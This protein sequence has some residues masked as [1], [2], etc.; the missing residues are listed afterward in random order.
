MTI[1]ARKRP[2]QVELVQWTGENL[3][4]VFDFVGE[5]PEW[6]VPYA[7]LLGF[8]FDACSWEH[9]QKHPC[10]LWVTKGKAWVALPVGD[11]IAKE[12]DEG[13]YPVAQDVFDKTYELMV[14]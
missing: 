1:Y 13:F 9:G 8:A 11:Y 7:G 14:S 4:E 3:E 6:D 10:F 2:I 5:I 12:S